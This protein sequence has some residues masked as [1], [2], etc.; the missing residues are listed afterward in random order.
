MYEAFALSFHNYV[1]N[2]LITSNYQQFMQIIIEN[3]YTFYLSIIAN[4]FF[5]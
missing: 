3:M 2:F 1:I 4:N 5:H